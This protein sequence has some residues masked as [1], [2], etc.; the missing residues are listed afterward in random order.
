M[1]NIAFSKQPDHDRQDGGRRERQERWEVQGQCPGGTGYHPTDD[2]DQHQL[3]D[4]SA[5]VVE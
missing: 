3:R 1:W 5:R 4:E 2:E